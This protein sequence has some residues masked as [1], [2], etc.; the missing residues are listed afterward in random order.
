MI[1]GTCRVVQSWN[2]GTPS[3]A[4]IADRRLAERAG[5][6]QH[7]DVAPQVVEPDAAFLGDALRRDVAVEVA[8]DAV[9]EPAAA[10]GLADL[11]PVV[12]D[13]PGEGAGELEARDPAVRL[14]EPREV[15]GQVELADPGAGAREPQRGVL[16]QRSRRRLE[17][18]PDVALAKRDVRRAV[19][20]R[21]SAPA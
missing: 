3:K 16:D 7:V 13:L 9:L 17:L 20:R 19:E 1:A 21:R 8:A 14:V 15:G 12:L 4:G 10:Q 18:V 11:V 6:Q 2:S 5:R